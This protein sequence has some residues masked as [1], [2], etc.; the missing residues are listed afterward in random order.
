[1]NL[2][3]VENSNIQILID[4]KQPPEPALLP[5]GAERSLLGVKRDHDD[6]GKKPAD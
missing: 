1:L 6:S 5:L 4:D 2:L 3:S